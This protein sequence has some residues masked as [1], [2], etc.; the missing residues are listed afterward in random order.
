M[1]ALK[2]FLL[3]ASVGALFT[4]SNC[5]GGGSTPEPVADQQLAKLSK[6]WKLASVTLDGAAV[7]VPSYTGFQLTITGT[8]GQTSFG[9][10]TTF[11]STRPLSP[12][13]SSGTWEFGVDPLKNIVRDK[14]ITT[15][16][17]DMDYT[18]TGTALTLLFNFQGAGYTTRTDVVKG[19]WVFN[20]TAQ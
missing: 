2:F 14:N 11:P 1:K 6:T 20:F 9:Y 7:T 3:I 12:W 16:K 13:K 4:F 18:V 19:N 10:A 15:D 5:G 8:K 17:V